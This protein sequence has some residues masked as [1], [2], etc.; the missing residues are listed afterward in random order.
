MQGAYR[1]SSAPHE[2]VESFVAAPGPAGWRYFGRARDA[3]TGEELFKVDYIVDAGWDLVRFRATYGDGLEAV[4][5][6]VPFGLEVSVG[7]P[8][9]ERTEEIA[10]ASAVWSLSPCSLLV[11]DRRLRA[12]GQDELAAVRIKPSDEP[13]AVT[14]RLD[15][16]G[17]QAI[18]TPAGGAPAERVDVI[19]DG[20]HTK[21]L[22]RPDLPLSAEG[23]FEL[24][25]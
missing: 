14:V 7:Q 6:P 11:V 5:V 9:E 23:W 15:R 12:S 3:D 4:V 20:W 18:P 25:G 8:G 24:L 19:V 2:L 17:S 1:I 13:E 22:I 10:G 16:R 21:A